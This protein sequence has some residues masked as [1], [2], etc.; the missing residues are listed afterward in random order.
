MECTL[1][2]RNVCPAPE[3]EI[4]AIQGNTALEILETCIPPW[5][6]LW[7]V[8]ECP[9][10]TFAS[11]LPLVF[12]EPHSLF[13][14]QII[15]KQRQ[16]FPKRLG[17]IPA[18]NTAEKW[19]QTQEGPRN[20]LNVGTNLLA[21]QRFP[22]ATK[23]TEVLESDNSTLPSDLVCGLPDCCPGK[24]KTGRQGLV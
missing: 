20:C 4:R 7:S 6:R 10:V 8:W 21:Y 23:R 5:F 13:I 1:V 12:K 15:C 18:M 14:Q 11:S 3:R 17:K 19:A 16:T 2:S 24:A 22:W 9:L